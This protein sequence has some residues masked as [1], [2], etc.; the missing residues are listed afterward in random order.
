MNMIPY[1]ILETLFCTS[2]IATGFAFLIIEGQVNL[3]RRFTVIGFSLLFVGLYTAFG[4]WFKPVFHHLDVIRLEHLFS[5]AIPAF[6]YW[7]IAVL[8]ERGSINKWVD[9]TFKVILAS[10]SIIILFLVNRLMFTDESGIVSVTYLY[11]VSYFPYMIGIMVL[12]LIL[13]GALCFIS[14]GHER[15]MRQYFLIGQVFLTILFCTDVFLYVLHEGRAYW[16]MRGATAV[17]GAIY[18]MTAIIV[19][20]SHIKGMIQR[21]RALE[22]R[23]R[24]LKDDLAQVKT[25]GELGRNIGYIAHELK[26]YLPPISGFADLIKSRTGEER[27]ARYASKIKR[28]ADRLSSFTVDIL[29]FASIRVLEESKREVNILNLVKK[30]VLESFTNKKDDFNIEF[31]GKMQD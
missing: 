28:S 14:R 20:S 22:K 7:S 29:K 31:S 8:G 27:T 2:L 11:K 4:V 17:G 26:N 1:I 12:L 15:E 30:T 6:L 5:L 21:K 23:V 13:H 18:T 16:E 9:G 3:E 19:F 25:M 10:S 24:G